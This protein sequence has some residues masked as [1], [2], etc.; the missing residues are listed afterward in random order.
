MSQL[1]P[2]EQKIVRPSDREVADGTIL[3]NETFK[4]DQPSDPEVA[5]REIARVAKLRAGVYQDRG[6][7]PA[8]A[9]TLLVT[10][11]NYAY[12]SI[13]Q[14]WRCA[15]SRWGLDWAVVAN[16]DE[17]YRHLGRDRALPI[18]GRKVTEMVGWGNIKLDHVGRNKMMTIV[19]LVNLTGLDV[20]FTDCDNVFL[21]DPFRVGVSLGDLIR[22]QKYQYLY[23]PELDKRPRPGY[24]SPGDG[25]NTGFFYVAGSR[26]GPN[27]QALFQA[28]VDKVDAQLVQNRGGAD[29]PIFWQV[30]NDLRAS[31]GNGGKWGFKCVRNCG[32]AASCQAPD[33]DTLDY[34]GL[35]PLVHPTGWED[36]AKWI[37][38]IATYHANY[39]TN[40]D[41]IKKLEKVG[42]W[43]LWD[44][45]KDACTDAKGKT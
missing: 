30:F 34:C 13:Y 42:G 32:D 31:R 44:S 9:T 22:S 43:G 36:A 17:S 41:K 23:Q 21:Q 10:A 45:A 3:A 25:G 26:K 8:F 39:A 37:D 20:V 40:N 4:G 11:A 38:T 5:K 15:A 6:G 12:F 7:H 14:N 27:I 33:V 29:Q 28:V 19:L 1:S 2:M 16:D 35:D 18:L 24:R